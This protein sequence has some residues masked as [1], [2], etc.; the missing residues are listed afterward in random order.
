MALVSDSRPSRKHCALDKWVNEGKTTL[1]V[2]Y[3]KG[4]IE[5]SFVTSFYFKV[6]KCSTN[7]THLL[8]FN[9]NI[10]VFLKYTMAQTYQWFWDKTETKTWNLIVSSIDNYSVSVLH[11]IYLCYIWWHIIIWI[12]L[13]IC[14]KYVY[15]LSTE[16]LQLRYIYA[17][18]FSSH[19]YI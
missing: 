13:C 3:F 8:K 1:F 11:H 19:E 12:Q 4:I 17:Y 14:I 15:S 18:Y 5:I 7:W 6:V 10:P 9:L 16:S 2:S